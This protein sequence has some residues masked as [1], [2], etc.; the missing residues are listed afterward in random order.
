MKFDDTEPSITLQDV[1]VVEASLGIRFPATLRDLYIH[2][3]G[4]NPEPYVFENKNLD[5]VVTEFLPLIS[6]VREAAVKVYKRLVLDKRLV[7]LHFFPFAID[8]GGDYFFI[9]CS[10]ADGAVHFYRSDSLK[11]EKLLNLELNFNT[12]WSSLKGEE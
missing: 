2:A 8:G 11:S 1:A 10:T 5:T 4:G 3:N 9:D 6:E 7:P 12:F